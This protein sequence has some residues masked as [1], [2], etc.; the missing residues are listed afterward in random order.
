MAEKREKALKMIKILRI[1]MIV[2]ML[3]TLAMTSGFQ[4]I[5]LIRMPLMLHMRAQTTIARVALFFS[6]IT[7]RS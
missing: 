4:D 1:T 2:L 6:F 3:L 5:I 7:L